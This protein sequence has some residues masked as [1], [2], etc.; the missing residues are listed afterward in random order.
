MLHFL[1]EELKS[2]NIKVRLN[3][4]CECHGKGECDQH[5][6]CLSTFI[7]SANKPLIC[8][9]DL[10]ENILHHQN[11]ANMEKRRIN[12]K[13]TRR[14]ILKGKK[15]LKEIETTLL[16]FR[17]DTENEDQKFLEIKSLK[18]Y[19]CFSNYKNFKLQTC[20]FSDL[21]DFKPVFYLIKTQQISSEKQDNMIIT[22]DEK[23]VQIKDY[24][25]ER[26]ETKFNTINN[27]IL[28]INK[29]SKCKNE[30]LNCDSVS[31]YKD[32]LYSDLINISKPELQSELINHNHETRDND[33]KLYSKIELVLILEDH[34]NNFHSEYINLSKSQISDNDS[35]SKSSNFSS[36]LNLELFN[37]NSSEISNKNSKKSKI[38]SN[39]II[40]QNDKFCYKCNA[41][42]VSANETSWIICEIC[43]DSRLCGSCATSDEFTCSKCSNDIRKR[44]RNN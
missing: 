34:Y 26:V 17:I 16:E 20:I 44:I 29:I 28:N 7:K 27:M 10:I 9:N 15:P 43:E 21:L 3:F 41:I 4:F 39:K 38:Y 22:T 12:N 14:S 13:M 36:N 8:T 6:S 1:F 35:L 40:I 30:C 32:K 5:F 37:L 19:Y 25:I 18:C 42:Y 11:K 2:E 23:K 31:L 33:N 24:I